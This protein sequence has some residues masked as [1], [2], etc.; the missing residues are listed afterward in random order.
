MA[1]LPPCTELHTTTPLSRSS[2]I[3]LAIAMGREAVSL[4]AVI[5]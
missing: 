5:L 4:H 1:Q 3:R 2:A